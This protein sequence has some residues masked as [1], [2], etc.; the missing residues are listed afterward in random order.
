MAPGGGGGEPNDGGCVATGDCRMR[1]LSTG[2]AVDCSLWRCYSDW[3]L[4]NY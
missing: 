4:Q 1:R 3:Y 2:A